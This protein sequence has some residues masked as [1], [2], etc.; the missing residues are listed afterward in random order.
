MLRSDRLILVPLTD[1]DAE[2]Y[3]K[4]YEHTDAI[5]ANE[6]ATDFTNRIISACNIV[7]GI[8]LISNK[9]IIIGDCALHHFDTEHNEIQIGGSLLPAYQHQ[10]YMR[11]AFELVLNYAQNSI[12]VK[13]IYGVTTPD[14]IA[15]IK[16]VEKLGF[17]KQDTNSD[18][19]ILKKSL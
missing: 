10:G 4:L 16:L 19:L 5:L 17:I 18:T 8:R 11:E 9:D 1:Q 7:W 14:N 15:A 2:A 13:T 6:T 12:D 3:Y